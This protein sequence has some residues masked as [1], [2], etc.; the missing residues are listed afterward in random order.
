MPW[1]LEREDNRITARR[2]VYIRLAE[3]WGWD[4][5]ERH[6]AWIAAIINEECRKRCLI[7][8]MKKAALPKVAQII[9]EDSAIAISFVE[10]ES[11]SGRNYGNSQG[12]RC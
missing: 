3:R 8:E 6:I 10:S 4:A 11:D 12:G 9:A 1:F 2:R 5:V 7:E